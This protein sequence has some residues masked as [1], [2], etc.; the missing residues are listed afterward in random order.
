MQDQ[1]LQEQDGRI[2][3]VPSGPSDVVLYARSIA[4]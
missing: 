1:N 4:S 3:P 2:D